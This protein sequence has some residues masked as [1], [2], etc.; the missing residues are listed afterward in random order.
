MKRVLI[1]SYH[2]Q[3]NEVVGAI[4][5]R[6]M[7]KYL[8]S[9]GWE[10]F[11]IC[12]DRGKND[13][14]IVFEVLVDS[15]LTKWKRI[16][17]LNEDI[18]LKNHWNVPSYKNKKT[19]IDY[20]L[21]IW[22]DIFTNPDAYRTWI[23]PAINKGREILKN[24]QF[25][26]IISS[27]G[28]A[29]VNMV[30]AK[31]AS[32]F[33]L[34]WIADFRDLWTQNH[35]YNHSRIRKFFEKKLELRTLARA[36]AITTVSQPLAEKLHELHKGKK[37]YVIP[38]GFD[39]DQMSPGTRLTE[40]FS[41]T[42]TG[43]LYQGKRDPELL[44][45][46][47]KDLIEE[48]VFDPNLIEINFYGYDEGWLIH[49]VKKY[50]LETIVKIHGI[51]SREQ[52]IEKQRETQILLLL[53]WN[54][55]AEKGVYTGKLFD[56]LAA[57][58]P[59]LSLGSTDGGVV[60]ELLDH[61]QAGVHCSNEAELREYLLKAY[62]EYRELGAVQYHGIEAEVMKYSHVEM[63][64]KFAEVLEEVTTGAWPVHGRPVL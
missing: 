61:T 10:N 12:G 49:D 56:Y 39:P 42:Y 5:A 31:L 44:F 58:R 32:E 35:Y 26:A 37:V 21:K 52:S 40:K 9:Y 19:F 51:I 53:T 25:H 2:F 54:D 60:R 38:N 22:E 17:G 1:I 13:D 33:N 24:E 63:A 4:R 7:A 16:L 29:S 30:A 18:T 47:I 20:I 43:V 23:N 50:H 41:I 8:K 14:F 45:K 27:S 34:P 46:V 57:R 15:V 62:R 55:P 6:G 64:R 28:P 48:N 11:V 36:N 3:K 59:I